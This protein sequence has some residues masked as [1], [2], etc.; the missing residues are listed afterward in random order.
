MAVVSRGSLSVV[1]LR[2]SAAR[3]HELGGPLVR[4]SL[5]SCAGACWGCGLPF[6][7]WVPMVLVAWWRARTRFEAFVV[8]AAYYGVAVRCLASGSVPYFGLS[9]AQACLLVAAYAVLNGAIWC[10]FWSARSSDGYRA[11]RRIVVLMVATSLP[12]LTAL[13]IPSPWLAAGVL[14]PRSGWIGLAAFVVFAIA[15]RRHAWVACVCCAFGCVAS[16]RVDG[17]WQHVQSDAGIVSTSVPL[18][19]DHLENDL[20]QWDV[21]T[22]VQNLVA[23]RPERVVVTPEGVAGLWTDP[24]P[25]LWEPLALS[26]ASGGRTLLVGATTVDEQGLHAS[27]VALGRDPAVY[28]QRVPMP[29]SMWQPFASSS[30]VP[31]WFGPTVLQVSGQ[32]LGVLIC[33]E[34]GSV[35]SLLGSSLGGSQRLVGVANMQWL[36]GTHAARAQA[37]VLRSWGLLFDVPTAL[38]VNE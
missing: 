15:T 22:R 10:L 14:F 37:D 3:L 31:A 29:L 12:P 26:F 4:V 9:C 17:D 34:I 30:F 11:A 16:L 7:A 24:M 18:G 32:R 27:V 23:S 5:A 20:A 33:W 21:A 2:A 8:I 1:E 35:W 13:S 25:R 38:A 36:R 6:V 19:R 28:R